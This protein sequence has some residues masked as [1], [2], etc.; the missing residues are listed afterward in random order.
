[1][2]AVRFCA[3]LIS[4][5]FVFAAAFATPLVGRPV[6]P[7]IDAPIPGK[8]GGFGEA[9]CHE[10][11]WDNPINEAPGRL[12][13]LGAPATYT[14]G[15]RYSI[16]VDLARPGL[17]FGGFQLAARFSGGPHAGTNAGELRSIDELAERVVGEGAGIVYVQHTK[18]GATAAKPGAARWTLEW[19]APD[20][21]APVIFHAA[22]NASNGDASSLGDFIY[23]AT[24]SSG[25]P[26]PGK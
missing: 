5:V 2:S 20:G 18:A 7:L 22:A 14:P 13:L 19:T 4:A 1:M 15:G 8:T 25:A 26:G 17:V 6:V 16:I 24:A 12:Q 23:T 21:D 11:H 10:C 9:T 3:I